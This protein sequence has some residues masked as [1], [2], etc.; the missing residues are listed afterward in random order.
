M[1]KVTTSRGK[2]LHVSVLVL[3]KSNILEVCLSVFILFKCVRLKDSGH[4]NNCQTFLE[5]TKFDI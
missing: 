2:E 3:E 4:F 5:Q 1:T